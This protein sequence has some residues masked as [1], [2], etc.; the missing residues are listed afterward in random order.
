LFFVKAKIIFIDENPSAQTGIQA[1]RTAS[2][3]KPASAAGFQKK[4]FWL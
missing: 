3:A 4:R 1:G 2:P